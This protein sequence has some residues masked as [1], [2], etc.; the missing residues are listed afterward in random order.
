MTGQA[1][2]L[3]PKQQECIRRTPYR[4]NVW[5]GAIRSGKTLSSIIAWLD[6][7]RY[8]PPGPLAMIGKTLQTLSR[9]VLDV[10]DELHPAAIQYTRGASTARIM[11][12][13]VHL[14]GA[15]N[16]TAEGK[17]RGLTLAGAY[18]DEAT[19]VSEPF[20]AQLLGRLSVTGAKLFCT[21]NPDSNRHW[22]MQKYIKRAGELSL[23]RHHFRLT[24]NPSLSQEYLDAISK[25]FTGLWRKRFIEGLWVGAD[26]AVY[27]LWDEEAHTIPRDWV[28]R[29]RDDGTWEPTKGIAVERVLMAGLD[30][31]QTHETR[32][33]LLGL[34]RITLSPEGRILPDG[35]EPGQEST[36]RYSLIVLDEFAPGHMTVGQH[37]TKFLEWLKDQPLPLWRSPEWIAVD[38]AAKV[39]RTELQDRGHSTL[40][41]SNKVVPGIQTVASLLASGGLYVVQEA[42]PHLVDRIPQYLWDEKATERGETKPV[43]EGDDEVDALRYT[44]MS[45]VREWQD[46]VPLHV[47]DLAEAA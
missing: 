39:F 5:D 9:N 7:C 34:A 14:F 20:F 22:L 28:V 3:S 46:L 38:P 30:Y 19:L 36:T 47:P 17:I 23:I 16:A 21:T 42:N 1:F 29:K 25:E 15:N 24:D 33:Y 10:I 2:G 27:D 45:S 32:A 35:P 4:I 31:G 44:V 40:A 13:L 37:A 8:G 6:F 11:G 41:A 18:L 26:G 43:K 12:R